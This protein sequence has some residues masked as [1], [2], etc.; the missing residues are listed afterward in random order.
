MEVSTKFVSGM[1]GCGGDW[2]PGMASLGSQG[3]NV[4]R[5]RARAQVRYS[6]CCSGVRACEMWWGVLDGIV[7]DKSRY[8]LCKFCNLGMISIS[9]FKNLEGENWDVVGEFMR[10]LLKL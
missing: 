9:L 10:P 8:V 6:A 2:A 3:P 7:A 4:E 1:V 5:R